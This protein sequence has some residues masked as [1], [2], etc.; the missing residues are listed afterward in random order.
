MA[1]KKFVV[2]YVIRAREQFAASAKKVANSSKVMQKTVDVAKKSMAALAIKVRAARARIREA[3]PSIS[4]MEARFKKL[5]AVLRKSKDRFKEFNKTA[6]GVRDFG[7]KMA[8][9]VTVP[10][11]LMANSFKNAARDAVE[12]RSKFATIFRDI[13]AESE[14]AADNLAK[15]FLVTRTEARKLIGD[16][17]DILT[18]F[19]F[20]QEKALEL[21]VA[22]NELAADLASFQNF[23]GGVSG[24]SVALTKA[25]LGE[26]ESV[27]AL[28]IV[29]RQD[30]K[31]YQALVEHL[32]RTNKVSLIQAKALAALHIATEQSKNS[33]G[34]ITRTMAD[35]A[36]Q[37]RKTANSIQDMKEAFGKVLL[38]AALKLTQAI[39]AMAEW[40]SA[41]SPRALK[42]ILIVAGILA[43]LGPLL[44][45]VGAIGLAIPVLVAGFTALGVVF[46]GLGV[47]AALVFSP[48][49]L[50]IAGIALGA[51]LVI[52]NW[53]KV[54]SF[55]SGMIE[56]VRQ[57]VAVA[58]SFDLSQF[59]AAA[60]KAKFS[61][62]GQTS[63]AEIGGVNK[64]DVG[65]NV[66]LAPGLQTTGA[67]QVSSTN[68]RRTDVGVG[69]ALP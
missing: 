28:G 42:M 31:E 5:N 67:P 65:V 50:A 7:A 57:L 13:S 4:S 6:K 30:T 38:P 32:A 25:L 68:T 40:F 15:N 26:A 54:K 59:N 58:T 69:A 17:A 8:I 44:L 21:G 47:V 45:I 41:L 35:L 62:G 20:T 48:I 37:E 19:G 55:F 33:I 22:V 29:I 52:K 3:I 63:P 49:G 24:A 11:A 1:G 61:G 56:I 46:A 12:T 60:I 43:V 64:V 16:T 2:E 53:E 27:K 66:G 10:V 51:L 34:D 14:S 36:N 9:G 39:R 18:G 23:E